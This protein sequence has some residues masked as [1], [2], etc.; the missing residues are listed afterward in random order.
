M[1]SQDERER[2]LLRRINRKLRPQNERVHKTLPSTMAREP[3][4][5]KYHLIDLCKKTLLDYDVD[6]NALAKEL[7]VDGLP[8]PQPMPITHRGSKLVNAPVADTD[9]RLKE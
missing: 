1:N 5:G 4:F 9:L 7:G 6:I 3:R 8:L 2:L